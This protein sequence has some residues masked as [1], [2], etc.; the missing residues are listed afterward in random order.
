M[1]APLILKRVSTSRCS[2]EWSGDD[3]DVLADGVVVGRESC[4]GPAFE[5]EYFRRPLPASSS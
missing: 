4:S 2:D 1:T 3:Y 5:E